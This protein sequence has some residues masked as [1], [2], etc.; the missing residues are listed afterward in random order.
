MI[1]FEID[2]GL[3]YLEWRVLLYCGISKEVAVGSIKNGESGGKFS[4]G[5]I[6]EKL[7]SRWKQVPGS[8]F[9]METFGWRVRRGPLSMIQAHK[10]WES[11]GV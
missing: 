6:F 3:D 5:D 9:S 11:L 8:S 7:D 1:T 10:V 4:T 2:E